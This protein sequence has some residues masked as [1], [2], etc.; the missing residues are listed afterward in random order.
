MRT[1]LPLDFPGPFG[2]QRCTAL[3][4]SVIA[5]GLGRQEENQEDIRRRSSLE[6]SALPFRSPPPLLLLRY[7]LRS[8]VAVN[9]AVR[10]LL[11]RLPCRPRPL[12]HIGPLTYGSVQQQRLP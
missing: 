6:S 8:L 4:A 2:E 9:D 11:L 10:L 3:D 7:G 12:Q 1:T 5:L